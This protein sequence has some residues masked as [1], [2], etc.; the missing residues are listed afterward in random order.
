MTKLS[1]IIPIYNGERFIERCLN[2]IVKQDNGK[3]EVI[4]VD[5]GSKDKS[6][7]ICKTYTEKYYYVHYYYKEN[8]GVSSARNLGLKKITGDY[9]WFVDIDDEIASGAINEVFS[10]AG[11]DLTVYNFYRV[12]KEKTFIDLKNK[13]QNYKLVDY[14]DF[15]TNFIFKY[16]LANGPLNKI[17]KMEIIKNFGLSFDENLKIGE[18]FTFNLMYYKQ[19]KNIEFKS[20]PI[21]LYYIVEG[22]AMQ[23]KNPK[24]FSYQQR[25]AEII[26]NEYKDI[27]KTDILEQFLLMQLVCGINQAKERGANKKEIKELTKNYIKEIMKGKRFTRRVVNNFLNSENASFLS[28]IKFKINYKIFIG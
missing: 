19:I 22:S 17:Y 24:A 6:A 10:L 20:A 2:S 11:A 5:D 25:I 28:K 1:I 8:G 14:N 15:F 18:D 26:K 4:L 13:Q 23:S 9:V 12:S 27:L 3:I 21:Y 16:K 7:E